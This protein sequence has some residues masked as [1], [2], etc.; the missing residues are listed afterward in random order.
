[1]RELLQRMPAT[2]REVRSR[3]DVDYSNATIKMECKKTKS[4]FWF[5]AN[6][7]TIH[8]PTSRHRYFYIFVKILREF[9]MVDYLYRTSIKHS[10]NKSKFFEPVPNNT[11]Y[12]VLLSY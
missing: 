12:I 9:L 11:D 2:Q 4:Y 5:V 3:K 7:K 10:L 6:N 8:S 1:M